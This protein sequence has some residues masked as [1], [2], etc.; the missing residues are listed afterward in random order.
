M[1]DF[2]KELTHTDAM[3][4]SGGFAGLCGSVSYLLKVTEEKP[5][6]WREFLLHVAASAI[7]GL[8]AFEIAS[9][10]GMPDGMA[11]AIAGMAGWMGTRVARI[12]EVLIRKKLNLSDAEI[13]DK[14]KIEDKNHDQH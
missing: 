9:F 5:F 1:P 6:S 13:S 14:T 10:E 11:G 2:I 12:I 3:L 8:I 7:F 4:V